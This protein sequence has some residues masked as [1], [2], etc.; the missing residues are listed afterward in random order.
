MESEAPRGPAGGT[1]DGR[2]GHRAA[3]GSLGCEGRVLA[4]AS[5][6]F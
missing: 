2:G 3:L 6:S 5:E 1:E 4:K